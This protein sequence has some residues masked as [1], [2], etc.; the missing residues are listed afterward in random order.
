[1]LSI[2]SALISRGADQLITVEAVFTV[3]ESMQRPQAT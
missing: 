2:L 1:M 3:R